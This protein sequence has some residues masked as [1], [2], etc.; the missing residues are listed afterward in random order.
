MATPLAAEVAKV[1]WTPVAVREAV[2]TGAVPLATVAMGEAARTAR[3]ASCLKENILA[4]GWEGLT[5]RGRDLGGIELASVS[6]FLVN[7]EE[8]DDCGQRDRRRYK[9]C[10][11]RHGRIEVQWMR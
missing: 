8:L 7:R 6:S 11:H 9:Y 3:R 1:V 4:A 2:E 5:K 10:R